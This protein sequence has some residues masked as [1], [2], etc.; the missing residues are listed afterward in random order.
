MSTLAS[1][2]TAAIGNDADGAKAP[3]HDLQWLGHDCSWRGCFHRLPAIQ[4]I[5]SDEECRLSL[6]GGM[7][8][9]LGSECRILLVAVYRCYEI[10]KTSTGK[11]SLCSDAMCS[12]HLPL[13]LLDYINRSFVPIIVGSQPSIRL[14]QTCM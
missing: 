1:S 13:H 7:A 3:V 12:F 14:S 4:W 6:T 11:P 10:E 5:K 9:V 8:A 2:S